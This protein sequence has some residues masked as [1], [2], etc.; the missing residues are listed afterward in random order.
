MTVVYKSVCVADDDPSDVAAVA[1]ILLIHLSTES[2]VL[3]L[4]SRSCLP[5]A[6]WLVCSLVGTDE[7][8]HRVVYLVSRRKKE[9]FEKARIELLWAPDEMS[10]RRVVLCCA[11]NLKKARSRSVSSAV[12]WCATK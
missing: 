8:W 3:G 11:S 5:L 2:C 12:C 10:W 7:M 6:G 4:T 1:F 9:V